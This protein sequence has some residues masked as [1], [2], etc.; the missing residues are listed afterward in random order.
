MLIEKDNTVSVWMG[1]LTEAQLAE[2]VIDE[3]IETDG[4]LNKF[5]SDM[6]EYYYDSE[7]LG[8]N[9]LAAPVPTAELLRPLAY[10]ETYS[11]AVVTAA[12]KLG[13]KAANCVVTLLRQELQIEEWPTDSPLTFIGSFE[14][15]KLS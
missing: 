13:I 1:N 7:L 12:D 15:Q 3:D 6:G 8:G 5:A 10:A 14:L 9:L 11:D 4:P 2:Y